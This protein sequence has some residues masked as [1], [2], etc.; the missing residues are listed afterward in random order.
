MQG[1]LFDENKVHAGDIKKVIKW[2]L[3]MHQ[4]NLLSVP[5]NQDNTSEEEDFIIVK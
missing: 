3:F 5:T 2:F 4:R 1:K